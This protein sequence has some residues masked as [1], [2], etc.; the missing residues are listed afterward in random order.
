MVSI[1]KFRKNIMTSFQKQIEK[2]RCFCDRASSKKKKK[3]KLQVKKRNIQNHGTACN[4]KN[5]IKQKA[6]EIENPILNKSC[7]Q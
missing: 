4:D 5:I 1:S 6:K 2:A 7:P 3:Q